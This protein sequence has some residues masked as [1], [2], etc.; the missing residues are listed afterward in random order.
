MLPC[1]RSLVPV[2]P[3]WRS[4]Q[5]AC[6][7]FQPGARARLASACLLEE[8]MECIHIVKSARAQRTGAGALECQRAPRRLA[9][10]L[11]V[12]GC[13]RLFLFLSF[14]R[15]HHNRGAYRVFLDACIRDT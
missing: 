4:R 12:K 11:V 1:L 15:D 7:R 6:G 13:G 2:L 5:S 8:S 14:L 10:L 3:C 9:G